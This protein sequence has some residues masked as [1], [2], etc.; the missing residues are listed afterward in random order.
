MIGLTKASSTITTIG[1][2][3]H[4]AQTAPDREDSRP[5]TS[6]CT[7]TLDHIYR[8]TIEVDSDQRHNG[9][10]RPFWKGYVLE[11]EGPMA[12]VAVGFARA[13][14]DSNASRSQVIVRLG[15]MVHRNGYMLHGGEDL[16]T[17][18]PIEGM[19]LSFPR[20]VQTVPA[21]VPW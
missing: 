18:N 10:N 13:P 11:D 15:D 20:I 6:T 19:P 3:V 9:R 2:A 14:D 12:S 21:I 8:V 7:T 16:S 17:G 4:I 5:T 1:D